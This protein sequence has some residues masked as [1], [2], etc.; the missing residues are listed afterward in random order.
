MTFG[1]AGVQILDSGSPGDWAAG[2]AVMP[3]GDILVAGGI[4]YLMS[5]S[6]LEGGPS[7][8]AV[9]DPMGGPSQ[10]RVGLARPNPA[11]QGTTIE[12][13]L[14]AG[15]SAVSAEVFDAAGRLVRRL[16]PSSS[17]P[18]GRGRVNWDGSGAGGV[19]VGGGVY[20]VRVRIAD[21]V[22]TR[23]VVLR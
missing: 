8:T 16:P 20:F 19:R 15:E 7:T 6:R 13:E 23:R 11:V 4:A 12:Y 22:E 10:S 21:R 5:A 1:A 2:V 18:G 3:E 17:E 14:P 9:P